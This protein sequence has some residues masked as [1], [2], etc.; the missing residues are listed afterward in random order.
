M[1]LIKEQ[2]YF[3]KG[4]IL[5]ILESNPHLVFAALYCSYGP[6]TGSISWAKRLLSIANLIR[7][8]F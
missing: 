1:Q 5:Y 8:R 3:G 7:T 4:K 6:Y 2:R